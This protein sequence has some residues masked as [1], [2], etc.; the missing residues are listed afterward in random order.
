MRKKERKNGQKIEIVNGAVG[1]WSA[2]VCV[3]V[4]R[5]DQV[6]MIF[7]DVWWWW[8]PPTSCSTHNDDNVQLLVI[9][10]VPNFMFPHCYNL[11]NVIFSFYFLFVCLSL[12]I[13]VYLKQFQRTQKKKENSALNTKPS[14]MIMA[15]THTD[16]QNHTHAH[17]H[18][19]TT[20]FV[21]YQ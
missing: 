14:L 13:D 2:C 5:G 16:T 7:E 21:V 3:C 15:D 19:H 20:L 17:T 11:I 18:T 8:L 6:V 9:Q 1:K 12:L 10:T 4:C